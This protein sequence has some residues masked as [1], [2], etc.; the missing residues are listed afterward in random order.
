MTHMRPGGLYSSYD[1]ETESIEERTEIIFCVGKTLHVAHV[2]RVSLSDSRL[3]YTF[4]GPVFADGKI[5]DV[6][7]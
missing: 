7:R 2:M 4:N 3:S 1:W 5:T 6:D